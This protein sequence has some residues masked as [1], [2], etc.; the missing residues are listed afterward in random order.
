MEYDSG[1]KRKDFNIPLYSAFLGMLLS[2]PFYGKTG[3]WSRHQ[4]KG[5]FEENR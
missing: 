2:L 1:V 4:V 3:K 5:V